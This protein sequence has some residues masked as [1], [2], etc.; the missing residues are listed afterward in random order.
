MPKKQDYRE[1]HLRMALRR[2]AIDCRDLRQSNG[3]Q[4]ARV[5]HALAEK[6]SGQNSNEV[7]PLEELGYV[8]RQS[9]LVLLDGDENELVAQLA[10]PTRPFHG[11]LYAD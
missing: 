5:L 11:G 7:I 3:G 8:I 1:I 9:L 6:V 10:S 2:I 4:L